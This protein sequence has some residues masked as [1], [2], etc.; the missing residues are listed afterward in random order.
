MAQFKT[1][2]KALKELDIKG[3]A[4]EHGLHCPLAEERLLGAGVAATAL[5]GG[6]AE[7]GKES[8]AC[9]K[10]RKR[11]DVHRFSPMFTDV[12]LFFSCFQQFWSAFLSC[13]V[14]F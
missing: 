4:R 5:F 10:A 11:A 6:N 8:L 1:L 9:F 7:S 13:F 14:V 2:K 3:F 12:H